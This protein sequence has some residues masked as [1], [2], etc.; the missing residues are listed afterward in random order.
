MGQQGGVVVGPGLVPIGT[1]DVDHD[2]RRGSGPCGRELTSDAQQHQGRRSEEADR[3]QRMVHRRWGPRRQVAR[4]PGPEQ[5]GQ[6]DAHQ[7][8]G[9]GGAFGG[10]QVGEPV[11]QRLP[12][13]G[14]RPSICRLPSAH[15]FCS[16]SMTGLPALDGGTPG[17][18]SDVRLP[19]GKRVAQHLPDATDGG[20]VRQVSQVLRGPVPVG[21]TQQL[22]PIQGL[23]QAVA[24]DLDVL[25]L[26]QLGSEAE[27]H[28]PG[29]EEPL[30]RAA[31]DLVLHRPGEHGR[32][33]TDEHDGTGPG[34]GFGSDTSGV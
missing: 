22:V 4:E 24:G 7:S 10:Q 16:A 18:R 14:R 1:G 12:A 29:L 30:V 20:A 17:A 2:Q 8:G 26:T 11:H 27:V 28:P 5:Q 15:R 6:S 32:R 34:D 3:V 23:L 25:D 13:F 21:V 33:Q 9:S 31:D 19:R